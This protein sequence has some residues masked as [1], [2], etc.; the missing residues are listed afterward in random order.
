MLPGEHGYQPMSLFNMGVLHCKLV[1]AFHSSSVQGCST[2]VCP[3]PHSPGHPLDA[4][5]WSPCTG[6]A[7]H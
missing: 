3:Q 6:G 7:H 1:L 2:W 4:S 5:I